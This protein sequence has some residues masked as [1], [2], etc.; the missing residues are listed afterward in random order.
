MGTG[1]HKRYL[2]IVALFYE[3]GIMPSLVQSAVGGAEMIYNFD[4]NKSDDQLFKELNQGFVN[5][6]GVAGESLG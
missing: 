5:F 2:L 1:S 3:R 4:F 6:V